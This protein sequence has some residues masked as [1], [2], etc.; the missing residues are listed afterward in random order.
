MLVGK[1]PDAR[2]ADHGGLL[3]SS[4]ANDYAV[5]W[6]THAVRCSQI[7]LKQKTEKIYMIADSNDS[8][9]HFA[10]DLKAPNAKD[11]KALISS[12]G[13]LAVWRAAASTNTVARDMSMD[14]FDLDRQREKNASDYYSTFLDLLLASEAR[15]IAYGLGRY[16]SL[17]PR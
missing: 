5:K 9:R 6:A 2:D 11:N 16:G 15:C 3:W 13:N 10:H 17:R 1:E 12:P 14:N 7:L 4:P 8:I